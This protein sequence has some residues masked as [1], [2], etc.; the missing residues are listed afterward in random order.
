MTKQDESLP[1]PPF[2]RLL[3]CNSTGSAL[4]RNKDLNQLY[5]SLSKLF[6]INIANCNRILAR[7]K[8]GD[9][10]YPDATFCIICSVL[11]RSITTITTTPHVKELRMHRHCSKSTDLPLMTSH[12]AFCAYLNWQAQLFCMQGGNIK[13]WVNPLWFPAAVTHSLTK[14]HKMFL[15][16]I[17]QL[18]TAMQFKTKIQS[19]CIIW[20]D[21]DRF[22]FFFNHMRNG[23]ENTV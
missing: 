11:F 18:H 7:I 20:K 15:N 10:I 16:Q 4:P 23:N 21:C 2:S 19:D 5:P 8:T 22:F 1:F 13:D 9:L 6:C 17:T 12:V 14:S 3:F